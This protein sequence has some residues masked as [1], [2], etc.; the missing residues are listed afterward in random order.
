ME[1]LHTP[2]LD[3]LMDEA[4]QHLQ[5][6]DSQYPESRWNQTQFYHG[7]MMNLSGFHALACVLGNLN[8][9]VENGGFDQW[10]ANG[11]AEAAQWFMKSAF[12][13]FY[14]PATKSVK[15]IVWDAYTRR[16]QQENGLD[17]NF[18]D[19]DNKYYVLNQQFLADVE[20][21]LQS[22]VGN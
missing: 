13:G 22:K 4:Y 11:Y 2:T 21:Y 8:Y 14:S 17:V 7:V 15:L 20:A 5:E 16:I 9:Q 12:D 3:R 19:L 6:H 1:E 10:H 18:D